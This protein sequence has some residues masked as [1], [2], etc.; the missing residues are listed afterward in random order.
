MPLHYWIKMSDSGYPTYKCAWCGLARAVP[1]IVQRM[2]SIKP[3]DDNFDIT[4]A[5]VQEEDRG[6]KAY[7][8][9]WEC[10][11]SGEKRKRFNKTIDDAEAC[12]LEGVAG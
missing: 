8:E 11:I 10:P 9:L 3:D 5:L 6:S 12:L 2:R 4:C 1:L 7:F